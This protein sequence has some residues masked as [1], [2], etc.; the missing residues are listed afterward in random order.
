MAHGGRREVLSWA[1]LIRFLSPTPPPPFAGEGSSRDDPNFEPGHPGW[2]PAVF[3]GDHRAKDSILEVSALAAEHDAGTV[4]VELAAAILRARGVSAIV[5]TTKSHAPAAP[6][7]RVVIQLA[8]GAT[9]PQRDALIAQVST[10]GLDLAPAESKDPA[11]FWFTTCRGAHEE[12]GRA[13]V[14][15]GRPLEL[16]EVGASEGEEAENEHDQPSGG[17]GVGLPSNASAFARKALASAVRNIEQAGKGTR[18]EVAAKE[19]FAIG[20]LVGAGALSQSEAL[21]ALKRACCTAWADS[22][23]DAKSDGERTVRTQLLEGAKKPRVIPD[24]PLPQPVSNAVPK[25][26][27]EPANDPHSHPSPAGSHLR[28]RLRVVPKDAAPLAETKAGVLA[29]LLRSNGGA[30]RKIVANA[31]TIFALDP[32]WSG[33]LAYQAL[34]DR[35]V[36]L[37]PPAWHDHDRPAS[38]ETGPWTDA[39]TTRTQAWLSREYGLDLGADTCASAIWATAERNTVDPLKDYFQSIQGQWDGVPRCNKWLSAVFGAPLNEYTQAIGQRWLIS[40]VARAL[41]AGCKVDFVLV[42][43][44]PQGVGKSSALRTLCPLPELF[45]DDDLVMGDKDAAQSLRG[46]WVI[47]LGELGAL[48]RHDLA[49]VK[50]FITRAVDSYRPSFGRVARDFPRRQVFAASTNEAEYLKDPTGNRRFWP[51]LVS[52]AVDLQAL[53]TH[54]DQLW[55]EALQLYTDGSPWWIDSPELAAL[56]RVEQQAREQVDPWEEHIAAF[57]TKALHEA[58]IDAVH[59][60]ACLCARCRGVTVSA[61][62]GGALGLSREKQG[63]AEENRAGAILRALGWIKASNPIRQDGARVR[64]YFPPTG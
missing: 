32:R 17:G 26:R 40:A 60:P 5:V 29:L 42:L 11:R 55:A 62:L 8:A 36:K 3:R 59:A 53:Q 57:L 6:R 9:I 37:Y 46:K 44:G 52:G 30:P 15:E 64:P 14:I 18:H 48:S 20:G 56:A 58:P 4:P 50:A 43:E 1:D 41:N 31:T 47:E 39:D 23:H 24:R 28:G 21:S 12:S 27:V 22:P 49:V 16:P 33:V 13:I 61:L 45:F 51:V 19:A 35:V 10:W 2:S 54:R 34:S 7:W 38:V 25:P 63:R